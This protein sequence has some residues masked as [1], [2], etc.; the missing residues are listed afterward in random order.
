MGSIG[1]RSREQG[2]STARLP[3]R[4]WVGQTNSRAGTSRLSS[5][6]RAA[7]TGNPMWLVHLN[8]QNASESGR[9]PITP[10]RAGSNVKAQSGISR[11]NR[12]PRSGCGANRESCFPSS[13]RTIQPPPAA[14]LVPSSQQTFAILRTGLRCVYACGST[15]I[16]HRRRPPVARRTMAPE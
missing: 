15:S 13:C 4:A 14:I 9:S 12:T 8:F 11:R 7:V 16:N 1:P 5:P 2:G 3:T 10:P 6:P